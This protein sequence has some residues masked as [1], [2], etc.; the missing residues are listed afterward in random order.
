MLSGLAFTSIAA[1]PATP[2]AA[3]AF[4][5]YYVSVGAFATYTIGAEQ[6][7]GVGLEGR[8]GG[9]DRSY[10]EME[11]T[12]GD[13]DLP[14]LFYAG[15]ALRLEWFPTSHTRLLLAGLA[16]STFGSDYAAHGELGAGYRWGDEAGLATLLGAELDISLVAIAAHFEPL[17]TELSPALGFFFP[18]VAEPATR[19]CWVAGRPLRSTGGFA[20]LPALA[21]TG[22]P[23]EPRDGALAQ[24]ARIW[25][26]RAQTELASV[27]AF[28]ELA[29]QLHAVHAPGALIQRS[30][31]AARDELRHAVVAGQHC[32]SL[33]QRHVE[34]T[35]R[36]VRPRS[37]LAGKAGLVRLAVESWVDGCVGEGVAA[38]CAREESRRAVASELREAQS[39]IASD[40]Q[41]HADLA[42]D[43]LAWALEAGGHEAREALDAVH[44][45]APSEPEAQADEDLEAFGILSS[46]HQQ[47]L[48]HGVQKIAR[49]R[50]TRLVARR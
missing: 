49:K 10:E 47:E 27:P 11:C 36:A 35:P 43:V 1:A 40:E 37:V 12:V 24:A 30:R 34:L 48:A 15:G 32:A 23:H 41:R 20:A 17:R 26:K 25:G 38:A 4:S 31:A 33:G 2:C 14:A 9:T 18:T 22:S 7:L 13:A 3:Q 45:A 21:M 50:L 5:E 19:S 44:Q 8:V 16:G 46:E 39:M 6:P 28:I 29:A 42:W